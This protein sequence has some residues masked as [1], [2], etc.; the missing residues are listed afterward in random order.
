MRLTNEFKVV[1][2]KK[3]LQALEGHPEGLTVVQLYRDLFLR[4]HLIPTLAQFVK[5]LEELRSEGY[6][7][8]CPHRPGEFIRWR[9]RKQLERMRS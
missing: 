1:T 7:D 6:V 3:V 8:D 2:E 5:V 4:E 9:T